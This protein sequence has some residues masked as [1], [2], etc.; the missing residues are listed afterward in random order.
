MDLLSVTFKN[1]LSP[2]FLLLVS[3]LFSYLL[4]GEERLPQF[5]PKIISKIFKG[6]PS[7]ET[8]EITSD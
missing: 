5:I 3:S 1:L 4:A 7:P 2:L 8:P 6:N